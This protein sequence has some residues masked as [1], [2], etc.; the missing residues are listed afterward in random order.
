MELSKLKNFIFVILSNQPYD[1]KSKTNKHYIAAKLSERG[2]KVI[3]VDPPTRFKFIKSILKK[4][5]FELFSKKSENLYVYYPVNLFNFI[6]F[7]LLNN[8]FHF[9]VLKFKIKNCKL[10]LWTYHFDFPQLFQ[11]KSLLKPKVFIYDCVDAYEYFPE[12]SWEDITN[13]GLVKYIQ[14]IDRYLKIHVDQ[15]GKRGIDWVRERET[16]LAHSSDL[17]FTSHPLLFEKFKKIN[18][19]TFY[20]PNAGDFEIFSKK[21]VSLPSELAFKKPR[22]LYSGALDDYKFDVD[23]VYDIALKN[24]KIQYSL[25]GPVNLSDSTKSIEKLKNLPNIHFVGEFEKGD[26]Y[27]HFYDAYIIPYRLNAYTLNGCFPIKFFNALSCGA[28]TVVT[29]F[30]CY[31]EYSDVLYIAKDTNDFYE[32]LILAINDKDLQKKNERILVASENT[33]NKKV[34]RQLEYIK[35]IL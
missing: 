26:I 14:L 30:P 3:F 22:V 35:S 27:A 11:L 1:G 20:T 9:L 15:G 33:W 16:K 10:I 28:P 6:P 18:K 7:S 8:I 12:Y 34:D 19:N 29:N 21:P 31:E 4:R 5:K 24:S 25:I 32:K 13:T 17:I 2:F 23:L